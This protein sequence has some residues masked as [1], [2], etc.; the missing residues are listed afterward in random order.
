MFFS[1]T[2]VDPTQTHVVETLEHGS[3]LISCRFDPSG[4]FVCFGAQDYKVWRW[5]IG[6]K[7]KVEL[8]HGAWV[9]GLAFD[10][11]GKTL[12]TAGFDQ[13]LV[14][15]NV[16]GEEPTPVREIEAHD[17]WV[18][19]VSIDADDS[20]VATCG[21]DNLVQ[22]WRMEDGQLVQSFSGHERHVYN[23]AFH[24]DG[25]QL[26]SGD[27]MGNL[28][29]WDVTS[30]KLVRKLAIA[31]LHKYDKTFKADIGGFRG[32]EFSRDGKRL[33]CAGI[34]NVTNAFAGVGNPLVEVWDWESG[35]QKI[36]HVSKGKLR[37]V[38]WGVAWHDSGF[39]IGTVGGRGG[40][41][42]FWKPEQAEEFHQL[43]L[44]N[45]S[46]DL[47]ISPDGLH[48]ATAHYDGRLRISRMAAKQA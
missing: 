33:A 9:R 25:V 20:L 36:A 46:R 28:M 13:R 35:K 23:V 29:H 24:P 1:N 14:W 48:L 43:K 30:G 27:L 32:L 42:L 26:V 16:T 6:T 4:Q 10:R 45:D 5:E 3:P 39:V 31:S 17:G 34:T 38:A 37:G 40:Y 41:L 44:P 22:V 2:K 12:L 19:A 21:N 15:W 11:D 18:R 47:D 8:D 7:N